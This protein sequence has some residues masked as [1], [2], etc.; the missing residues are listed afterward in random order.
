MLISLVLFFSPQ[1]KRTAGTSAFLITS[2][3][4]ILF[5]S[6]EA[7]FVHV[8]PFTD[9]HLIELT[10]IHLIPAICHLTFAIG[11]IFWNLHQ[12]YLQKIRI[13]KWVP[14]II[15]G[16]LLSFSFFMIFTFFEGRSLSL[17]AYVY[18]KGSALKAGLISELNA[19][20]HAIHRFSKRIETQRQIEPSIVIRD[21]KNYLKDETSIT[22]VGWT[23]A[24]FSV[25]YEISKEGKSDST[26][27][28]PQQF[29]KGD[30]EELTV[31]NSL[32][33]ILTIYEP[34]FW[35]GQ[36]QGVCFFDVDIALLFETVQSSLDLSGF[37][38]QISI[39]GIKVFTSGQQSEGIFSYSF[40]DSVLF[41]KT[42]FFLE[43]FPDRSNVIYANINRRNSREHSLRT[44]CLF[45]A[46]KL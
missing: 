6:V 29:K 25:I 2:S 30:F 18:S 23:D 39:A 21:A 33:R 35:G 20:G 14:F 16:G 28:V 3:L 8:L 41:G 15:S 42:K 17:Q 24:N 43:I 32:N 12:D 22:R 37:F 27:F 4:F 5:V 36:F 10:Q 44:Y 38:V 31:Y 26:F 11:L 1:Q 9:Q 40:S 7:V 46:N 34:L 13:S 19:L 45:H